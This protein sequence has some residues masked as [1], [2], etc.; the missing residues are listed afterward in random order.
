MRCFFRTVIALAFACLVL[1]ASL[2]VRM[3]R[4][5]KPSTSIVARAA[6]AAR[7]ATTDRPHQDPRTGTPCRE[8]CSDLC[9][10]MRARDVV[11]ER[12]VS[13][14]AQRYLADHVFFVVVT[15]SFEKF[16]RIDVALCLWLQ[17]VPAA[18]A[19]IL[20]DNASVA[21]RT[22]VHQ[23]RSKF[24]WIEGSVPP[25][26]KFTPKQ[27]RARGYT[28]SWIKAQF[29]F[30]QGLL[31]ALNVTANDPRMDDIKWFV[32]VDDDTFT[33]VN[34]LVDML[35]EYDLRA[36]L[37]P[38]Y[39]FERGWGGAGHVFSAHAA[40]LFHDNGYQN[41]VVELMAHKF[42]ASDVALKRCLPGLGIHTITESRMS[43]CQANYLRERLLSGKHVTSHV[44][45]DMV[46]PWRFALWRMRLYYQTMYHS[47]R[48]A[49][50]LLLEVGAC[51]YGSCRLSK[52]LE[53]HDAA[54]MARFLEASANNT[55]VPEL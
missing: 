49:Y 27:L 15:G 3:T 19:I 18:N 22:D 8:G 24:T 13:A 41:C 26:A 38:R 12:D 50:Q 7:T 9:E 16:F 2:G 30:T 53:E 28:L 40:Q 14:G 36:D 33:N 52:C 46:R 5:R 17:H 54:A 4:D 42:F 1:A 51:A 35:K 48:T 25:E 31:Y 34:A 55:L 47:N 21:L 20:S 45:R 29:R 32:I 23:R 43:H 39:L 44:K 6:L 10:L 11:A 37:R